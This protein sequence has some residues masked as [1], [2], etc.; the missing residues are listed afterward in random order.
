MIIKK[1]KSQ[2]TFVFQPANGCRKVALVGSFNDWTPDSCAMTRQK[3]GSFRKVLK[4]QPG[5]Y[6]YR[7]LVDGEWVTD[8]QADSV[9]PNVFGSTDSLVKVG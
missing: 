4:L 6:R 5:E 7:F 3:D 8:A 2:I 9:V 1:G